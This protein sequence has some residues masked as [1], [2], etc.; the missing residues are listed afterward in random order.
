MAVQ[1]KKKAKAK[2]KGIQILNKNTRALLK[3]MERREAGK[4]P[5]KKK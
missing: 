3:E 2:R 4:A 1:K 5:R